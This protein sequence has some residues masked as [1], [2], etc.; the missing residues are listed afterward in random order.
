MGIVK[1]RLLQL[2][3]GRRDGMERG[4]G[5]RG[6]TEE[7]GHSHRGTGGVEPQEAVDVGVASERPEMRAGAARL[8]FEADKA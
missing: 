1:Q 7:S 3:G 5:K 4:G 8:T 2:G 6:Q